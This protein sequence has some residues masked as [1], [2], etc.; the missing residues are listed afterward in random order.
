VRRVHRPHRQ[1]VLHRE[2]HRHMR[3]N[4]DDITSSLQLA[5]EADRTTLYEERAR[6]IAVDALLGSWS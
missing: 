4:A 1:R 3:C 5:P 2:V 6:L